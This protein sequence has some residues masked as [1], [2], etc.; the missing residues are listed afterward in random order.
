MTKILFKGAS[1][2]CGADQNLLDCLLDSGYALPHGCRAG[3]CQSCL[4]QLKSGNID[5]SA[6]TGLSIPDRNRGLLL[7]CQCYPT[8][9]LE[10]SPIA[11]STLRTNAT[12]ISREQLSESVYVLKL[13]SRITWKAGQ[14]INLW[15]P[16]KEQ[17]R[18]YSIANLASEDLYAELHVRRHPGGYLSEALTQE[19][20][21]GDSLQTQGPLGEFGH[22]S[23]LLDDKFLMLAEGTGLAPL[24][25]IARE[26]EGGLQGSQVD[27]LCTSRSHNYYGQPVLAQARERFSHWQYESYRSGNDEAPYEEITQGI[28]QR[29]ASLRGHNIYVCGS[30]KFVSAMKR[31]CFLAGA[32]S[33]QII[34]ETF[35]DFTAPGQ[36]RAKPM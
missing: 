23:E 26:I 7:A 11:A 20:N 16:G 1:L 6:Q 28:R 15:L 25:A 31:C 13:S 3:A 34:C 5:K 19:T 27:F 24:L 29:F 22:R 30:E 33:S 9:T 14:Y 17:T 35:V 10:V 8:E 12:L 36:S 21:L 18:S 4:L 32:P 2:D